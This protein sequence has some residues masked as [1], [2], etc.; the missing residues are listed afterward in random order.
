MRPIKTVNFFSQTH[1]PY[2]HLNICSAC[3][4]NLFRNKSNS[5]QKE[6]YFHRL[7]RSLRNPKYYENH[8]VGRSYSNVLT[9]R[10]FKSLFFKKLD[11][12]D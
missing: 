2:C 11:D 6:I 12:P 4:Y 10:S 7:V 8:E 1:V 9:L 3:L 5:L